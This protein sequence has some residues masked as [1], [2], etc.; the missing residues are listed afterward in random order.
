MIGTIVK[1]FLKNSFSSLRNLDRDGAPRRHTRGHSQAEPWLVAHTASPWV[2]ALWA[3]LHTAQPPARACFSAHWREA[4]QLQRVQQEFPNSRRPAT[5]QP[6]PRST[7]R[8]HLPRLPQDL[9][10]AC[11]AQTPHARP[12]GRH[13]EERPGAQQRTRTSAWRLPSAHLP[14][15]PGQLQAGITATDAQVIE[16]QKVLTGRRESLFT[17]CRWSQ[18]ERVV[19]FLMLYRH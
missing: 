17:S 1:M 8:L 7:T 9:L 14:R 11:L 10:S 4:V 18:K 15:L 19:E 2:P 6:V 13:R 3:G 5:P 16:V 12:R